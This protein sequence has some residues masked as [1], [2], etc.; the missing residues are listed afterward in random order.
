MPASA[1]DVARQ[2]ALQRLRLV[3]RGAFF[4]LFLL[5]PPLDLFRL[6]LTQGHFVFFGMNWAFGLDALT[7]GELDPGTAVLRLIG[8]GFI[9]IV[10]VIGVG[11]WI[12]WRYGRLYCGWLCPH[13][14]VVELIN[15][16]MRRASGKPSLWD[17][18]PLPEHESD[19]H[20]YRRNAFYWGVVIALA[21]GMAFVWAVA[22][23]TYLLPPKLIYANLLHGEL[24]RNQAL[25]IGVATTLLSLEFLFARHL[26]CRFGC[27]VGL[28]QSLAWMS[29]DRALV[30]DFDR[31]RGEA[32]KSCSQAC[33]NACPMR[34]NPRKNKR[35]MFTC[36]QCARCLEAC[37][38][39]QAPGESLLHWH[40]SGGAGRQ[41][42]NQAPT[43]FQQ[44]P[45]VAERS[46]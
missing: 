12:A 16:A 26:F 44:P 1:A 14:S 19:G 37:A 39:V 8:L 42:F 24:S 11:L 23:L 25:F 35:H 13:F 33:D 31:S 29:N 7:R 15:S 41:I 20:H 18:A 3:S 45:G 36:T 21:L 34:L 10:T 6:D 28:F 40:G 46:E 9:P 5:A 2:A 32:C 38:R 27:A 22:L 30:V 43:H 4:L 17:K